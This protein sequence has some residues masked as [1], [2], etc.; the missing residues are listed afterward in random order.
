M[1]TQCR[2]LLI[3]Q[4]NLLCYLFISI[5]Y[6]F[7]DRVNDYSD[8]DEE[9]E[10]SSAEENYEG[11]D[12]YDAKHAY[13]KRGIDKYRKIGHHRTEND[14]GTLGNNPDSDSEFEN[15]AKDKGSSRAKISRQ[16]NFKQKIVALLK[17]FKVP[18]EMD[19]GVQQGTGA[20]RGERDLDAFF[21]ELESLSCG[22][23]DDSGPDM[24]SLSIGSTPKPSL[25]PFFSNSRS[26]LHENIAGMNLFIT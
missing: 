24:D 17:R 8:E 16:R 10:F 19:G 21:Q 20:L 22:E 13:S 2:L 11:T 7:S 5:F 25:R 14:D 9:G 3:K 4:Y 15:L 26:M 18:E 12:G 1:C 23:G 6:F